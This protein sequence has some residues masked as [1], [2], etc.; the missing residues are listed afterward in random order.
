MMILV[1]SGEMINDILP[2]DDD[3]KYQSLDV[4][5]WNVIHSESHCDRSNETKDCLVLVDVGVGVLVPVLVGVLVLVL[6]LVLPKFRVVGSVFQTAK[7]SNNS[8]TKVEWNMLE[9]IA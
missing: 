9:I 7:D 8:R 4:N 6:V 2:L 3:P 5:T 1:G